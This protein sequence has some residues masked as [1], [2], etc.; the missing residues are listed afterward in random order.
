MSKKTLIFSIAILIVTVLITSLVI[1]SN[2]P[3][4]DKQETD[5][6]QRY[7]PGFE[8]V[9]RYII[10]TYGNDSAQNTFY[11]DKQILQIVGLNDGEKTAVNEEIKASLN[12]IV[13]AFDG[14]DFSFIKVSPERVSYGGEGYRMYV[15]SRNGKAPSYFYYE[16]DGM[17]PEVYKL[18]DNWYLL[19]VNYI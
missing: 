4:Q 2:L 12:S 7:K 8:K 6:F 19:K 10:E 5:K 16:G 13:P 1:V 9:N 17:K 11:L 3:G 14:Y 18:G 15:Y